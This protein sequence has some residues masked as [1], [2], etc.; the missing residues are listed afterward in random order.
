MKH[1]RTSPIHS[2]RHV[3]KFLL[4]S[5]PIEGDGMFVHL[6]KCFDSL[7][8]KYEKILQDPM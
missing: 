6:L 1:V 8:I 5:N 2:D 3:H 7:K 4:V